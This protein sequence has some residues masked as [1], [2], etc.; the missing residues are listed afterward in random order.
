MHLELGGQFLCITPSTVSNIW[1]FFVEEVVYFENVKPCMFEIPVGKLIVNFPSN[2]TFSIDDSYH[3]LYAVQ[4]KD[5]LQKESVMKEIEYETSD[6]Q[7]V[8]FCKTTHNFSSN[9]KSC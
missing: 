3:H 1:Q 7:Q 4:Y 5:S 6:A 8:S 2:S 9:K